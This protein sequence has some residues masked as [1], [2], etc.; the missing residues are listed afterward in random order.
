MLLDAG[1]S[2]IKDL[3]Y[4]DVDYGR[5]GTNDSPASVGDTSVKTPVTDTNVALTD[6]SKSSDSFVVN[7]S[8]SVSLGVGSNLAEYETRNNSSGVSYNR[9]VSTPLAKD[10]TTQLDQIH[11]FVIERL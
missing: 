10:S 6:K 2:R 5:A 7:H 4:A 1:L 8:I 11:T 9:L 3:I